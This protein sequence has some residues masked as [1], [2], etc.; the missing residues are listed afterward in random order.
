M[1]IESPVATDAEQIRLVSDTDLLVSANPLRYGLH[2]RQLVAEVGREE[3]PLETVFGAWRFRH[4]SPLDAALPRLVDLLAALCADPVERVSALERRDH[5]ALLA[6]LR[7]ASGTI[8]SLEVGAHLPDSFP[9]ASEL[10]VE[11]FSARR[12]LHCTPG[13]QTVTIYADG[14]SSH[15]WQPCPADAIVGAFAGWLDGGPRP[16]GSLRNDETALRL[17]QR[18]RDAARGKS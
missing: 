7:Y 6:T 17:V 15:D 5:G 11:C 4:G 12:A 9:D 13:N 2:T 10:V 1:L 8:A 16:V 3:G 18:V 14:H